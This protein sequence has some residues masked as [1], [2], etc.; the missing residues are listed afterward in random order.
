MVNLVVTSNQLEC[1]NSMTVATNFV[2]TAVTM[3]FCHNRCY[4]E[5]GLNSCYPWSG[6][7]PP[8]QKGQPSLGLGPALVLQLTLPWTYNTLAMALYIL[9]IFCIICK[10][11]GIKQTLGTQKWT[12]IGPRT[13][14]G[15]SMD[16]AMALQYTKH[17]PLY[18]GYIFAFYA[19]K[20]V[21]RDSG[22]TQVDPHRA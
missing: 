20:I 7:P 2:V 10:E 4:D 11:N 9:A 19:T 13:R 15:P 1:N 18:I 22:N 21:A 16:P 3:N 5:L 14:L 12:L 17:G 8:G 6:P